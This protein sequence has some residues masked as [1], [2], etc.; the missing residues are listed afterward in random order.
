MAVDATIA[1][2]TLADAKT[3]AKVTAATSEDTIIG[4]LINAV[5]Q[6]INAYCG[7]RFIEATYT[8]YLDGDGSRDLIL[9]QCPVVSITTLADDP[10]RVWGTD[11]QKDVSGSVILDQVAGLVTLWNQGGFFLHG[12]RNVKVVYIA[13]FVLTAAANHFT[14]PYEV[15]LACKLRVSE[16]YRNAYAQWR[17]G[18]QSDQQGDRNIVFTNEDLPKDIKLMLEPYRM[19]NTTVLG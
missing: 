3:F 19:K 10:L 6:Q 1:L 15:T 9:P 11:T 13:G 4:D 12:S 5:S 7:R 18:I 8:D 17:R 2:T 16:L 14:L